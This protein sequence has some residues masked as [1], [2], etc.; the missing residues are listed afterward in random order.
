MKNK[1]IYN[2]VELKLVSNIINNH[3][4]MFRRHHRNQ[5]LDD[6]D[7]LVK[8]QS[9]GEYEALSFYEKFYTDLLYSNN[10]ASQHDLLNYPEK[11]EGLSNQS[12]YEMHDLLKERNSAIK[13]EAWKKNPKRKT[14]SKSSTN[15]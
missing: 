12:I 7:T 2:G 13:K 1:I 8:L 10:Y 5:V 4:A 6:R 11:A 3:G 15:A 9:A 14:K